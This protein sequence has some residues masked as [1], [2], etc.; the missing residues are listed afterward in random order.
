MAVE[1]NLRVRPANPDD[2]LAVMTV[3]DGAMLEID[4]NT[5]ERRIDAGTVLVAVQRDRVL[6][7]LVAIP[8]REGVH[9]EAI[10]VR[11]RRRD[12]GIGTA[13]VEDALD[14]WGRLTAECDPDVRPFY[15]KL[16]FEIE[17]LG[18]RYRAELRD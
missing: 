2:H 18:E 13:L 11:R 7:A 12:Q 3:L 15:E 5:V 17:D 4:A 1:T 9:V 14:R 6:G 16:G 8:R 10:A